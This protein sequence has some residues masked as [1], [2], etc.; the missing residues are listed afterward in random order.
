[1]CITSILGLEEEY[2][3]TPKGYI[4][5][6]TFTK[7]AVPEGGMCVCVHMGGGGGGIQRKEAICISVHR[8]DLFQLGGRVIIICMPINKS[9]AN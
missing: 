9:H 2:P 5:V 8:Q 7:G 1:M 6:G 3:H 4:V